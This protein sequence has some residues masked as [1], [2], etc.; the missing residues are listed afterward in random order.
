[1]K[2][3]LTTLVILT[4]L[5]G[6][7]G[8]V[9][10][11]ARSDLDKGFKADKAS[12]YAIAAKWYRK[13]AEQGD[14]D[15]QF[16]LGV[17]YRK[18]KGVTQDDAEAVKWYRKSAEQGDA[19]AQYNLGLM[20]AEGT[21]VT[22]DTIAAHMWFNIA[23]ANGD[24]DAAKNRDIAAGKLSSSDIVK[25]QKRAKRCMSSGFKDCD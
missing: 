10:A 8:A 4:G 11:D 15:A 18:G 7:A 21:G 17:M 16:N 13:A 6:S 3:L 14:A 1:M 2:R 24:G 20:Y 22:Q 5:I 23:A 12:N 25:A 9:W 19:S